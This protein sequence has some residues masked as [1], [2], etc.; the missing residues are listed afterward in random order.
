MQQGIV[1][2]AFGTSHYDAYESAIRPIVAEAQLALPTVSTV[3]AVTSRMV[4]KA[5]EEKSGVHLRDEVEAVSFLRA[6]GVERIIV[7]PLHILPGREY[8]K[9]LALEGVAVG[10]PLF[11]GEDD[12]EH[13]AETISFGDRD[14]AIVLMGHGTDV[15][16]DAVYS[17]L[18]DA[19]RRRGWE[20]LWIGTVEG[21]RGLAEILPLIK[22]SRVRRVRLQPLML[23]AGDHA[24]ND[25][26]GEEDSWK[27][28]LEAEGI[29]VEVVLLGLGSIP[30]VRRLYLEKLLRY[31]GAGHAGPVVR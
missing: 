11:A 3:R 2:A 20:H 22:S 15:D 5:V 7:Q 1:L 19:Y 21:A 13:F 23:V 16:A 27:T 9:L 29:E 6:Q 31:A 10:E 17:R 26:A 18:E 8:E 25:M 4:Q 24:K 12:I 28:S 30:A 14:E